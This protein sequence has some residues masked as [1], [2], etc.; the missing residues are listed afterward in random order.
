MRAIHRTLILA[1]AATLGGV[2]NLF[3]QD[4][5]FFESRI[6]PAFVKYCYEYHSAESGKSKGGLRVD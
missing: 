3:A 2:A 6:R 5:A 1:L 4:A